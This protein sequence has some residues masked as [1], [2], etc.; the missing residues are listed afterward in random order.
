MMDLLQARILE[1]HTCNHVSRLPAVVFCSLAAENLR[2][3]LQ[4]AV[5][6]IG[7]VGDPALQAVKDVG[8]IDDGSPANFALLHK[9]LQQIQAAHHI[10]VHS[11]LI[12][13]Q[14]LSS[15]VPFPIE[16]PNPDLQI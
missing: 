9:E 10:Q 16:P 4:A 15:A 8:R 3:L 5:R 2:T 6:H 13:Q 7:Q 1:L 14:H 11:D 12:Q